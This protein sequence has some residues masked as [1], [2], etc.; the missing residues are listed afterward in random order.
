MRG[1]E[2]ERPKPSLLN[3]KTNFINILLIIIV[4]KSKPLVV[5]SVLNSVRVMQDVAYGTEN[6][7]M[8]RKCFI[9]WLHDALPFQ[10]KQAS[11]F[12]HFWFSI[13]DCAIRRRV[14]DLHSC[15]SAGKQI[16]E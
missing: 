7:I 8:S 2:R 16:K 13:R 14:S 11:T 1:K 5:M 6:V 3:S 9:V 4:F 10:S 12:C 15:S